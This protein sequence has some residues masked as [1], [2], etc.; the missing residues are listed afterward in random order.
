[1]LSPFVI[2]LIL[3]ADMF[4]LLF[5]GLA[6]ATVVIGVI[7]IRLWYLDDNFKAIKANTSYIIASAVIFFISAMV[8][9]S[10]K[11]LLVAHGITTISAMNETKDM[12]VHILS[13]LNQMLKTYRS[14]EGEK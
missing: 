1:M 12:P 10:T 2:Y 13:Q 4:F 3:Q 11:S 5:A 9:P 7:A 6:G 14:E 8:I